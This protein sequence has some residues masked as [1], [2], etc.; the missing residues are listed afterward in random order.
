MRVRGRSVQGSVRQRLAS[1]A[2][3]ECGLT[4]RSRRTA[5]PPLNSSV[6]RLLV[7][8]FRSVCFAQLR[9]GL[10]CFALATS[11]RSVATSLPPSELVVLG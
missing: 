6:S 11:F 7:L 3:R 1:M 5:S 10:Q 4:F 2:S 8:V 9:V